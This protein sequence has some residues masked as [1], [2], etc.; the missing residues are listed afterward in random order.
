MLV[1]NLMKSDAAIMSH[2]PQGK[3]DI[4]AGRGHFPSY[5][6]L[7]CLLYL[8]ILFITLLGLLLIFTCSSA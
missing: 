3:G 4:E 6:S 7:C 1:P 5:H 8:C 2:V